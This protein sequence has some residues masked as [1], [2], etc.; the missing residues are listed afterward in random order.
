MDQMVMANISLI[1]LP[2]RAVLVYGK[3][4][5]LVATNIVTEDAISPKKDRREK[6]LLFFMRFFAKMPICGDF[7]YINKVEGYHDKERIL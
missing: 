1:V 5:T 7:L 3:C 2:R 6:S 4:Q